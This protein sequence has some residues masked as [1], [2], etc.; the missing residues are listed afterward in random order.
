[1]DFI[2][3]SHFSG[4]SLVVQWLRIHLAMQGTLVRSLA[5]EDSMC[6]CTTKPGYLNYWP[7]A[8]RRQCA[9]TRES[10]GC[11]S[12]PVQPD[13]VF[14]RKRIGMGWGQKKK[15]RI[16]IWGD[17]SWWFSG[18][19]SEF[20]SARGAGLIP[21]QGPKI[22]HSAQCGQKVFFLTVILLF[23][24][25]LGREILFFLKKMFLTIAIFNSVKCLL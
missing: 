19:G 15:E 24:K 22:P 23:K 11:S 6:Q 10:K 1:M 3:N 8:F 5:W 7:G 20:S 9:T 18:S 13:K 16:V 12:H 25:K 2:K 21:G 14:F 17:F 4:T